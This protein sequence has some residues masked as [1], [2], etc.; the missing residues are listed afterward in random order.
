MGRE[1]KGKDL[2]MEHLG[3]PY[4]ETPRK[5]LGNRSPGIYAREQSRR[6]PGPGRGPT[7]VR[8]QPKPLFDPCRGR[9]ELGRLFPPLKRGG[10]IVAPLPG[11]LRGQSFF[12]TRSLRLGDGVAHRPDSRPLP[13]NSEVAICNQR[14]GLIRPVLPLEIGS[15]V[16]P[17]NLHHGSNG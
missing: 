2:G 4:A 13:G 6:K 10:T 11:R 16:R 12:F 7:T 1:R 3:G 15:S 9:D 8:P 14:L 5:G 17:A